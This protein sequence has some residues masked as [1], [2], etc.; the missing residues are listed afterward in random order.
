[1]NTQRRTIQMNSAGNTIPSNDQ[2]Q[3]Q[4]AKVQDL[5]KDESVE[6]L[7]NNQ[8]EDSQV[9]PIDKQELMQMTRPTAAVE[10]RP[11]TQ[12]ASAPIEPVQINTEALQMQHDDVDERER[13]MMMEDTER[14]AEISRLQQQNQRVPTGGSNIRKLIKM[15]ASIDK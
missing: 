1:M 3:Q 4:Q 10:Q 9:K 11:G 6:S 2:P 14:Q 12:Q 13:L 5:E 15:K 8:L 7:V